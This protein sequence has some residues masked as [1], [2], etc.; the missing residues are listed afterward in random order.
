MMLILC[1]VPFDISLLSESQ[2]SSSVIDSATQTDFESVAVDLHSSPTHQ[3]R[4]V[5]LSS[6]TAIATAKD[7]VTEEEPS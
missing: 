4:S 7:N 2:P 1:F 5:A 6:S 3:P